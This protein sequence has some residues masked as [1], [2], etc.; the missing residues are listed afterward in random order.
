M[1]GH[2][3]IH[4]LVPRSRDRTNQQVCILCKAC[5]EMVHRLISNTE[6]EKKY[7]TIAHLKEHLEVIRF[8]RWVK[9]QDPHKRI[10]IK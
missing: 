6:L 10:K 5:H 7:Y 8:I 4:H 3:T 9:K 1:T 2:Y